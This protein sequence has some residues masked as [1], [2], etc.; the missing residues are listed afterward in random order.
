MRQHDTVAPREARDL[1][2]LRAGEIWEVLLGES[3]AAGWDDQ[4]WWLN[5]CTPWYHELA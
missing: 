1:E 5:P 2:T 4:K 3:L